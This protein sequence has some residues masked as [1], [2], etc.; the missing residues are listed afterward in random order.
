MNM[1]VNYD[2]QIQRIR[3]KLKAAQ[4]ADS[5]LKVFGA[6][7]H[8]YQMNAPA[9]EDEVRAF[10][11]KYSLRLPG[12]YR[13]FVTQ[14]GNGG[15]Y[16]QGS[17]AGPFYGI[18]PL[19]ESV[20][21][22]VS[23]PVLFLSRPAILKPG[24]TKEEWAAL[25]QGLEEAGERSDEDYEAEKGRIY[26]G[27]M[28][29]GS[30][31][32]TYIHA[33]V[34]NGSY[35]GRVVNV[36][37]GQEVA[38]AHENTFLDW[39]ER[40]LDEVI[41]GILM[42]DGPSW[43]GYTMGGDDVHLMRVYAGAN[44]RTQRLEALK[45]LGKLLTATGATCQKLLELCEDGGAEVRRCAVQMLA[46]FAYPMARA[47][48]HAHLMGG[49]E[50]CLVALQSIRWYA[51]EQAGQW[52]DLLRKRLPSIKAEETF[53]F[54]CYLLQD[55]GVDFGEDLR[56]FCQHANEEIRSTAIWSL[57]KLKR[58][59]DFVDAFIGGLDDASPKVVH[60]ALQALAG[61]RDSRLQAA[62]ARVGERFKTEERYV[63]ANLK[64]RLKEMGTVARVWDGLRDIASWCAS[65][66]GR[67]R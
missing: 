26:A 36:D 28:P 31:G 55:A 56:P 29:L 57:G 35:E 23:D 64:L 16:S 46:K 48:L 10:E 58:K 65:G 3:A 15:P 44:S 5:G 47:P 21:E 32:C 40:W 13:A 25:T 42:Q 41:S 59:K 45:G 63:L 12:C 33:L 30:Q 67:E 37:L 4:K 52:V 8:R 9:S 34:L 61:V 60:T 62:Y 50:D 7:S 17:A 1:A 22:L 2:D 66:T 49:D 24:M 54:A 53:R 39:Y 51:G 14:I 18:Y 27:V 19:G 38:F 6:S 43:F 11:A 20:N